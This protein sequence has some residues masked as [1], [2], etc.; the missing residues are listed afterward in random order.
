MIR[1]VRGR[2]A[3]IGSESGV[4]HSDV[5]LADTRVGRVDGLRVGGDLSQ[6]SGSPQNVSMLAGHGGSGQARVSNWVARGHGEGCLAGGDQSAKD[7]KLN[8]GQG[9][10]RADL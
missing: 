8:K 2:I 3:R 9:D 7:D 1:L 10:T 6:I 5:G 4:A